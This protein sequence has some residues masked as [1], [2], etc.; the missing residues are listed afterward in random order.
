MRGS[1]A[2]PRRSRRSIEHRHLRTIEWL[3][4]NT[5]NTAASV[6]RHKLWRLAD[7]MG[8]LDPHRLFGRGPAASPADMGSAT[9]SS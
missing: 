2:I 9:T 4:K 7:V 1:L 8:M 5:P 3:L 6:G